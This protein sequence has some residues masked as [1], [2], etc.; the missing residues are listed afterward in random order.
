MWGQIQIEKY[1][2]LWQ[3]LS[4]VEPPNIEKFFSVISGTVKNF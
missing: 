4:C 3:R 2:W 1:S